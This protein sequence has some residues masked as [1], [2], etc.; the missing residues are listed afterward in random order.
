MHP[1]PPFLLCH[2]YLPLADNIYS[3]HCLPA[4]MLGGSM[5]SP[6]IIAESLTSESRAILDYHS[7]SW[8]LV[9]HPEWGW[10]VETA[11]A[12]SDSTLYTTDD[13]SAWP[14]QHSFRLNY[15]LMK[16]RPFDCPVSLRSLQ[17]S[18]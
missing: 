11:W 14:L 6:D 15:Q 17:S 3:A 16:P 10:F 5:I 9:P 8:V 7:G 18:C 1:K 13:V 4:T 12:M 2:H